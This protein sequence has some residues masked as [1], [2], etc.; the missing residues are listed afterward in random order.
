[1]HFTLLQAVQSQQQAERDIA[2]AR[3]EQSR[4]MIARRLKEH[5]GKN[6]E[7]IDEA[8][9]F[10]HNVYQDVLPS[11]PVNKPEKCADSSNN[12]V[13]GS[14]FLGRMVSSSLVLAGNSFNIKNLGGILGNSAVLA[15]GML[16]LLQLHWMASGEQSPSVSSYS[17]RKVNQESSSR[18]GT[19]LRSSTMNHLDG[20]LG[21]G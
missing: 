10:A 13:K 5:R 20:S 17:Y 16:T 14:N 18:L 12:M 3:L 1:M 6:H 4:I 8:S 9:K 2:L 15:I 21:K 11:L 19:S 7:V